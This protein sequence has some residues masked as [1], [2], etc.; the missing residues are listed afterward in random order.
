[1]NRKQILHEIKWLET[2]L[3][4]KKL[5]QKQR[6]EY[7]KQIKH[8]E[9]T[10]ELEK[11]SFLTAPHNEVKMNPRRER[12]SLC[13]ADGCYKKYVLHQKT[14]VRERF[15]NIDIEFKYCEDH[16]KVGWADCNAKVKKYLTYKKK[17]L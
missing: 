7:L 6:N 3:A 12:W 10:I 2:E 8:K 15:L 9:L 11:R 14:R 16:L 4:T 13:W 5:T 17:K 1:M